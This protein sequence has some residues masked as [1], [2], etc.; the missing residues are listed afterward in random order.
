MRFGLIVNLN[1][2][3]AS[4]VVCQ[5]AEWL[6]EHG[7]DFRICQKLPCLP[8]AF[9]KTVEREEIP[10]VCDYVI[11]MGGDGTL[12][13][14]A[15]LVGATGVPILGINLG[16]L[17]FLTQVTLGEIEHSLELIVANK[18]RV[19]N[20]MVLEAFVEGASNVPHYFAL[21]DV[22][23]DRGDIARLIELDLYVNEEF[24]ST[25]RADGVIIST[26]TGSTAYNA[27]V[28]GP[29]LHPSMEAIVLA[30]MA[31]QSLAARPLL[32]GG[33]A[34]MV[35][36]I[37]SDHESALLTIDGQVSVPLV[38]GDTIKIARAA[39]ATHLVTLPDHSYYEIL[40][41]KLNWAVLPK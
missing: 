41:N 27:A 31:P 5:V 36:K 26:P 28:G 38:S 37:S 20:R 24:I 19:E 12:L 1:R 14:T 30:P 39:H 3:Q 23:I 17:G 29:I 9:A 33:D 35:V 8:N 40:R 32:F 11:S 25:Y 2:P 7:H 22:V 16:S 15:R 6:T 10:R 21:N 4:D 34:K 18:H 13:A